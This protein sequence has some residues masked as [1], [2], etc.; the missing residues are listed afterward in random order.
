MTREERG[1]DSHF[2]RLARACAPEPGLAL[3]RAQEM[4]G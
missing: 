4:R 2:H 3:V 1:S